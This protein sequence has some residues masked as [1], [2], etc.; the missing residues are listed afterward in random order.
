[1]YF[2]KLN[3]ARFEKSWNLV[4]PYLFLR[5]LEQRHMLKVAVIFHLPFYGAHESHKFFNTLEYSD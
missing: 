4:L 1:M 2:P 3:F 5:N